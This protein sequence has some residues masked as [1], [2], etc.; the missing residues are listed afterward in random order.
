M[1]D[2]PK[3]P[4]I[5]NPRYGGATPEGAAAIRG[6]RPMSESEHDARAESMANA[7]FRS[8]T[9]PDPSLRTNSQKAS[10]AD[11]ADSTI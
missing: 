7:I 10:Q 11:S 3:R 1:T 6:S 9:P 5:R 2:K 8:E 4:E